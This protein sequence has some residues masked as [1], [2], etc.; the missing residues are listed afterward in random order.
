MTRNTQH[1]ATISKRAESSQEQEPP[2]LRTTSFAPES[3]E[4]T[5]FSAPEFDIMTDAP[6]NS[7]GLPNDRILG[8]LRPR[9][10]RTAPSAQRTDNSEKQASQSAFTKLVRLRQLCIQIEQSNIIDNTIQEKRTSTLQAKERH[11]ESRAAMERNVIQAIEDTRERNAIERKERLE[12]AAEVKERTQR[13][14]SAAARR[15]RTAHAKRVTRQQ[16]EKEFAKHF[17]SVSRQVAQVCEYRHRKEEERKLFAGI[18][19]AVESARKETHEMREKHKAM[20]RELSDARREAARHDRE[21]TEE[22]RT[23]QVQ[24]RQ[25]RLESLKEWKQQEREI[26]AHVNEL[27]KTPQLFYPNTAPALETDELEGAAICLGQYIGANLGA[28]ESRFICEI[29][30]NEL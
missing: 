2:K 27:R 7:S 5:E 18:Q 12:A 4:S 17:V 3:L 16:R 11:Q 9:G 26:M 24:K 14:R 15:I 8:D 25:E 21:I 10:V 1:A 22:R 6:S 23:F 13:T 28:I 20:T 30:S 29:L 19:A